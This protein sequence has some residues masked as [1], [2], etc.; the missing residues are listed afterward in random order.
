MNQALNTFQLKHPSQNGTK[1]GQISQN[2]YRR[3][4]NA[5]GKSL[6]KGG[7]INKNTGNILSSVGLET[8]VSTKINMP[9]ISV[10]R[11]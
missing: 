5:G 6:N 9:K 8:L 10:I 3:D 1:T 7:Q 4:S 2:G 11:K